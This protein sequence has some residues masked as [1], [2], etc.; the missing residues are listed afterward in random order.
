MPETIEGLEFIRDRYKVKGRNNLLLVLRILLVVKGYTR[1]TCRQ[2][3]YILISRFKYPASKAFYKRMD[4][5]LCK[6]RRANPE[7]HIKFIDPTRQ[8][9]LPPLP[10]PRMEIWV[11]KDSIRNFIAKLAVKYRL[12]IQVLRGFASL[13]I[14]GKPLNALSNE[15]SPRFC[16]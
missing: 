2:N 10:Y 13:S 7:V 16:T 9:V 8:F 4:R 3:Y 1:L 12:S 6:I 5:Y 11:E 14:T 15:A